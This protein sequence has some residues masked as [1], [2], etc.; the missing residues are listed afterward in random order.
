MYRL[1]CIILVTTLL[2][3]TEARADGYKLQ[4]EGNK[5]MGTN[6]VAQT[7]AHRFAHIFDFTNPIDHTYETSHGSVDAN[8]AGS[9]FNFPAGG[10]NDTFTYRVHSLWTLAGG[11]P[12]LAPTGTTLNIL[13]ASNG[14]ELAQLNGQTSTPSSFSVT[15]TTTHELIWAVPQAS[16]ATIFGVV[17]SITGTSATS[18]LSYEGS[19]PFVAVQWTSQF[20]GDSAAAV[21]AIYAAAIPGDYNGNGKAELNDFQ[22]WRAQFG[23]AALTYDGADGNGDGTVDAADYVV[24]RKAFA[25]AGGTAVGLTMINTIPEPATLALA[26]AAAAL[27]VVLRQR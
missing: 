25:A 3:P 27:L 2:S 8:D 16:S 15:A 18:G 23:N 4:L 24:W 10:P 13:K 1:S 7:K 6:N 20:S 12:A 5:I 19:D 17:Y 22:L 21:R 14:D 9:G 26:A 11:V